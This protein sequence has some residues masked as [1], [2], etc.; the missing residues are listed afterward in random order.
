M[1]EAASRILAEGPN[2]LVSGVQIRVSAFEP[3]YDLSRKGSSADDCE[4]QVSTE[5]PPCDRDV[6]STV[7]VRS[8]CDSPQNGDAGVD[9]VMQLLL[10]LGLQSC[11][12]QEKA[13]M[14]ERY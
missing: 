9:T 12:V 7:E 10:A 13:A 4:S 11:S 1:G 6:P 2:H 8:Q 14:P 3:R 5:V